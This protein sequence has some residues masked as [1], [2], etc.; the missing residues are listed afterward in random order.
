MGLAGMQDGYAV[1]SSYGPGDYEVEFD[2]WAGTAPQ[3]LSSGKVAYIGTGEA[4]MTIARQSCG[5]SQV[6]LSYSYRVR[7]AII[8]LTHDICQIC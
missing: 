3:S 2:A 6:G 4:Y 5:C 1:H 8:H 7:S